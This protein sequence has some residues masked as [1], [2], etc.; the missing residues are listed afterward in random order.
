MPV[1][2]EDVSKFPALF[3]ELIK[4]GYSDS[5]V[6][7]VS[8]LN[9]VRVLKAVENVSLSIGTTGHQKRLLETSRL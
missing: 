3:A 2:L 4:R 6:M 7:K 8:R 9:I 1:G 5:D